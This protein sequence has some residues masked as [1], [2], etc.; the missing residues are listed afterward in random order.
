MKINM[1]YGLAWVL[2]T[3]LLIGCSSQ[4][5]PDILI[6]KDVAE[7][8]KGMEKLPAIEDPDPVIEQPD[9]GEIFDRAYS[10]RLLDEIPGDGQVPLHLKELLKGLAEQVGQVGPEVKEKF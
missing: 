2:A 5:D 9:Y 8:F 7:I 10:M 4:E 6:E 3:G 1:S